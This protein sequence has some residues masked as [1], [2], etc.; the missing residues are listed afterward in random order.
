[1]SAERISADGANVASNRD[2][3]WVRASDPAPRERLPV[4]SPSPVGPSLKE[5]LPGLPPQAVREG[6]VQPQAR[7]RRD[8]DVDPRRE[9][10]CRRVNRIIVLLDEAISKQVNK[11]LHDPRFQRLESSWRG[12]HYLAEQSGVEGERVVRIRV[13]NVAWKELARDAERALEFDQTELFKKI[14]EQEYGMPGGQPFGVLIGDYEVQHQPSP[15]TTVDDLEVLRSISE[16]AAAAF[17]PF[18][19]G[20]HPSFL[21]LDT[22]AQLERQPNLDRLFQS[23]DYEKWHAR[24]RSEDSRFLGLTVPRILIRLPYE[25]TDAVVVRRYCRSCNATLER[26]REG[27]CETC[28]AHFDPALSNAF[29]V[30]RL[31]FRFHEDVEAPDRSGYLW[32]SAAFAFGAVLI[33]TFIDT[34]WLADI[35]G[36]DRNVERGGLVTGLP[37]HTFGLDAPEVAPKMSTD[38]AL[39][40][41]Q[42]KTL[43]EQGLIPLSHCH[44]TGFSVFF[45]NRSVHKPQTYDEEAA[46]VNARISSMLQYT[47]CV[48][49]FAHYLKVQARD[50]IGSMRE[51]KELAD[52]LRDWINAY[53][54][55]DSLASA[56]TKAKY[57]L[58]EADVQVREVP[59]RPGTY[60]LV[61]KLWPHYQLDELLV[62]VRLVTPVDG[63]AGT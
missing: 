10:F 54:T 2:A 31:G 63:V 14:Y 44:D 22:F 49:R 35:R 40:A 38:V 3:Q 19:C 39:D 34:G 1:M 61:M 11:I 62:S 53:V 42:E 23:P 52:S 28:G 46:T 43:A 5:R 37:A 12:L 48:S 58:R 7:R 51:P 55:Q 50:R 27:L 4:P 41:F 17:A 9:A 47:L 45:S 16:T 36:F 59:S 21:G 13:L 25:R 6:R 56:D 57:P 32:G 60:Q 30:E 15:E 18:I 24:R 26:P 8:T 29:R 20:I 33:R